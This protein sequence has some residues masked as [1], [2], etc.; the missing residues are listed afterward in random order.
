MARSRGL[1]DI[2]RIELAHRTCAALAARQQAAV[3]VPTF[4]R[5]AR[6]R[7]KISDDVRKVMAELKKNM[8]EGVDYQIVYDPTQF[9]RASSK[10]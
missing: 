2:A 4:R 8:P 1:R 5:P 10:R 9:V 3:A 6:T 7:S